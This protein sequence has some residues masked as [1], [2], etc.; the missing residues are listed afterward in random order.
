MDIRAGRI[1]EARLWVSVTS[2]QGFGSISSYGDT[3]T[4]TNSDVLSRQLVYTKRANPSYRMDFASLSDE[5]GPP[6]RG[7]ALITLGSSNAIWVFVQADEANWEAVEAVVD[8]I[9]LRVHVEG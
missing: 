4:I 8:D 2:D 9:F 1:P 5:E 7:A 3:K 6:Q